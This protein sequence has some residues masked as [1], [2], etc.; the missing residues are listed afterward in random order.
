MG[1]TLIYTLSDGIG[2]V[3]E[4]VLNLSRFRKLP[5]SKYGYI[6]LG[7]STPYKE[8]LERLGVEYFFVPKKKALFSNIKRLKSVLK[9]CRKT[10]DTI[11][12]NTSGL[13]YPVPYVFAK[14]YKYRLVL[15]SH[16]SNGEWPKSIIHLINRSWI[17]PR[18]D[19][20]L[21][22]SIYAGKW[23]FGK[24]DFAIPYTTL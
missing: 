9:E 20:R 19:A 16:S 2:G 15:H 11:Y 5:S 23:M 3:E 10:Y 6:V 12:F 24:K 8:E 7:E 14:I 17:I 13:Y 18:V 22:C 1:K 4:Y 21:A